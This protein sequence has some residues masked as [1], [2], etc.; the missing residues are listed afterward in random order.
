MLPR[1][2]YLHIRIPLLRSKNIKANFDR[3]ELIEKFSSGK[4]HYIDILSVMVFVQFPFAYICTSMYTPG[5]IDWRMIND[6]Y[7]ASQYKYK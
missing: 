6:S 2:A 7:N 3:V 1:F 4:I 5:S